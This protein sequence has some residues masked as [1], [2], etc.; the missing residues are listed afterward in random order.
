MFKKLPLITFILFGVLL[1]SGCTTIS[2]SSWPGVTFDPETNSLYVAFNTSVFSIDAGSGVERWRYPE[3]PNQ[4]IT[5]F[6]APVLASEDHLIV[7]GYDNLLYSLNPS[8][9]QENWSFSGATNRYI[10]SPIVI[11]GVIYAPNADDRVYAVDLQNQTVWDEPFKSNQPLWG[12]PISN[13]SGD[14]LYVA[15]MDHTAYAIDA[16]TA[17]IV[18]QIDMDGASVGT[19]ILSTDNQ[20]FV[21]N[22]ANQLLALDPQDGDQLWKLDTEG[23][24]WSGAYLHENVLY[25]GDLEGNFYAVDPAD[26]SIAWQIKPDGQVVGKAVA[27]GDQ[28]YFGTENGT[29]YAVDLRGNIVWSRDTGGSL[30]T[31]PV[32]AG[33]SIIAA[34]YQADNLLIAFNQEGNQQ[35][36]FSLEQ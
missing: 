13:E 6:A 8:T 11:N 12:S 1:L 27:L 32:V 23:W 30:Y 9:G 3:K 29:L 2:A 22:F 16:Q 26:G 19:P 36:T 4:R 10:A 28:I 7:G 21:G 5:F 15:G 14:T 18:W 25:M 24:I 34:P 31:G 17:E 33:D 20:L 35:W